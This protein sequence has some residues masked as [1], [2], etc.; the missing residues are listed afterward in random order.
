MI[1]RLI[2]RSLAG[3]SRK[4]VAVGTSSDASMLATM[5][6]PLPLIVVALLAPG[7]AGAAALLAPGVA[8]A[9]VVLAPGVALLA[10]GVAG[11]AV[12][13]SPGV[14]GAAALLA[15]NVAGAAV[16]GGALLSP[17][18]AGAAVGWWLG[19]RRRAGR[20]RGGGDVA[21]GGFDQGEGCGGG[22]RFGS[23]LVVEDDPPFVVHRSRVGV[24]ASAHL[25][26][27]PIVGAVR[28]GGVG[29]RHAAIVGEVRT[30]YQKDL[31]PSAA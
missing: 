16:V 10:P 9:A 20:L 19:G 7:V 3:I 4:L 8:G 23:V 15:P 13:L 6:A 31:G 17:G 25:V 22:S 21:G 1:L 30:R 12:V 24:P 27:Q 18:V 5:R 2:S 14:A 28:R 26:D 29:C 11:A